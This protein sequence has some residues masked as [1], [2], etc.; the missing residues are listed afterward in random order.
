[1]LRYFFAEQHSLVMN[2]I[3]WY[4]VVCIVNHSTMS[5]S[6]IEGYFRGVWIF[7]VP[8]SFFHAV[9]DDGNICLNC[10]L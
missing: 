6:D 3:L 10:R 5:K 9:F 8:F 2:I 1:M 4:L 7:I